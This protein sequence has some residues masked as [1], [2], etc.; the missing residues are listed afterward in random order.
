MTPDERAYAMVRVEGA[1]V[2]AQVWSID[3]EDVDR[4]SDKATLVMDDPDSTNAD[5]LREGLSLT[6]ELGWETERAAV[7]EG[8]VQRVE[9]SAGNGNRVTVV[10]YDLSRQLQAAPRDPSR[11][12]TGT[13]RDILT[14]ILRPTGIS[15]GNVTVEPMPNWN[16]KEKPLRQ[17]DRTDWELIQDLAEEYRARAFV[18]VNVASSDSAV[19]RSRGGR[20]RFYFISESAL[21]AQDPMGSLT[22]CPGH[23]Q[24]LEFKYR[25]VGSGASPSASATVA[26]PLTGETVKYPAPPTATEPPPTASAERSAQTA[27][28]IGESRARAY[29][30]AVQV[31]S[32][33]AVQPDALRATDARTGM[34]SD[35]ARAARRIQQDRTRVLGFA[36]DGVAMGTVFMRAKGAVK[37]SGLATWAAGNWYVTQV[38]H[39]VQ[40]AQVQDGTRLTYRIKFKATR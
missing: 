13:L 1:D 26:D 9:P 31:T 27:S 20:S 33:A 17:Q 10:A 8:C 39:L 11:Q 28:V 6:I 24:L 18:E 40:R 15:I 25:R 2:S 23:G 38:N 4:G 32:A 16:E 34:P 19:V 37:I 5:A 3:V 21:L 29:E 7:F 35:A 36:G 30:E 12:H 22:Y 14:E